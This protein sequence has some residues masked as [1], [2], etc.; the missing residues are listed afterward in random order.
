MLSS[1]VSTLTPAELIN[2]PVVTNLDLTASM[3]FWLNKPLAP[4]L[5]KYVKYSLIIGWFINI[6]VVSIGTPILS[7]YINVPTA[8]SEP[9]ILR[10]YG[11]LATSTNAVAYPDSLPEIYLP[12]LSRIEDK[13]IRSSPLTF[14][15]LCGR[16]TLP[17][18]N[19]FLSTSLTSSN[20]LGSIYA[21]IFCVR[22]WLVIFTAAIPTQRLA[23]TN[24]CLSL[25]R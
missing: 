18:P 16:A 3:F 7:K 14:T 6:A 23:V 8:K 22:E 1:R 19:I 9:I 20:L 21:E 2:V 4:V 24:A 15:V 12:A 17:S 13:D 11:S 5:S 25:V 10:M